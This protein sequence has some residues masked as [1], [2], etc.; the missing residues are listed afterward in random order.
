[1]RR[2][3]VAG[4]TLLAMGAGVVGFVVWQGGV[5]LPGADYC[6]ASGGDTV[7]RLDPD[8][9]HYAALITAV[10]VRRQLPARAA[11]IALAAAYQESKLANLDYGD[12]DSLGLFQQRPSQGWGSAREILDPYY[13]TETFYDALITVDGYQSMPIYQAAQAVQR[14]AD[15]TAY[16]QHEAWARVV[17]SALTGY[18]EAGF[19]CRVDSPSP[20]GQPTRASGLTANADA[21]LD[22]ARRAF[23]PLSV[24]GFES[25]GVRS[26][27]QPGSAHYEGRAVDFFFRPIDAA[28]NRRGWALAHYMVANAS[29]RAVRTVIFDDRIWTAA[30]SD[31]GWRHYDEPDTSGDPDV[32]RHLDHVH[33]DVA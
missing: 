6:E 3:V 19:T 20:S 18:S 5:T 9:A 25:G 22:D 33:V 26:G 29:R 17:A 13:A 15:G 24:G 4:A 12:R 11:S 7:A 16:R 21:L 10:A 1:M 2:S 27:H 32:L 30:R 31:E 23:G 8:Q 14:S 28:N